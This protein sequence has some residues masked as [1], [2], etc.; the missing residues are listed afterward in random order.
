MPFVAQGSPDMDPKVSALERAFQLARSGRVSNIDDIRKILKR[1]GYDL[2]DLF[3]GPSL[4][5]QLRELIK[6]AHLQPGDS[7]K[8]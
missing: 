2:I 4:K 6:T 5:S 7:V 3:V 1:E 8:R